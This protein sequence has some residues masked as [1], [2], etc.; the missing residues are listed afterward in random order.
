METP[1][2]VSTEIR[3]SF[4]G[5][6]FDADLVATGSFGIFSITFGIAPAIFTSRLRT[7]VQL[8]P[9][10]TRMRPKVKGSLGCLLPA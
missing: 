10:L 2:A 8:S 4:L 6:E 7:L 9:F 5:V 3:G 1:A